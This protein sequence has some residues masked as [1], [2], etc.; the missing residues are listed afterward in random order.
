MKVK[1]LTSRRLSTLAA[2]ALAHGTVDAIRGSKTRLGHNIQWSGLMRQ[3]QKTQPTGASPNKGL[4]T[5]REAAHR[6]ARHCHISAKHLSAPI[7]PLMTH[8]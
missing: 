8:A 6:N 3:S 1:A 5:E 4:V 7:A 2:S